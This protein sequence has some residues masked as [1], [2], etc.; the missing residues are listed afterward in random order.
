M[1]GTATPVWVGQT[2]LTQS[3]STSQGGKTGAGNEMGSGIAGP[4][5]CIKVSG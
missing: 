2:S 3:G 5:N 1:T 4:R